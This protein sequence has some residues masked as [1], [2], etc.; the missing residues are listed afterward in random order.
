MQHSER[1][2]AISDSLVTRSY[3]LF[4]SAAVQSYPL[5]F[6]CRLLLAVIGFFC[7]LLNYA[8]RVAMSV[9]IVAMVNHTALRILRDEDV[10]VIVNGSAPGGNFSHYNHADSFM[11]AQ[12]LVCRTVADNY[13]SRLLWLRHG[14]H[15]DP[16]RKVHFVTPTDSLR[17]CLLLT[18]LIWCNCDTSGVQYWCSD[19]I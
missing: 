18:P 19:I 9:T 3:Y 16:H 6:S 17:Q 7:F 14:A 1:G 12:D 10:D 15:C 4:V 11:A 8:Q 2:S 13:I 5:V